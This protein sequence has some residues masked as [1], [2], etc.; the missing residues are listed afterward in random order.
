MIN[1]NS[2]LLILVVFLNSFYVCNWEIYASRSNLSRRHPSKKHISRKRDIPLFYWNNGV[3]INFGDYLSLKL[4]ERIV[5]KPIRT[6]IDSNRRK[7][8][9]VGSIFARASNGDVVWGSGVSGKRLEKTDYTFT[10][11]DIRAVRGPL[12]RQFI[13]ENFNIDCPE[14]YGDP[15]LLFP[16]FFPEFK[17]K[18][19][20][21]YEY[22]IIPHYTE[23]K[24]FPKSKYENV[25]YPT[26]PWDEVIEKILDSKFVISSAMHG[27]IVA[28]AYHIPARM[29]RITENEPMFKYQDYYAGT[30][31]PNFRFATSVEEALKMGGEPQFE[32]DL[33]KL[34]AAFPFDCWGN[35]K[36]SRK[37]RKIID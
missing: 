36:L 23:Q 1:F 30:N 31:R 35:I 5:G 3:F 16:Y 9:A 14:V 27:L 18:E 25:V 10:N 12:T 34:Y 22:I 2:K 13:M 15:V 11:L 20:P 26:D 7:L 32:C 33:E 19:S 24:L 8:L 37:N 28:E 29:L 21:S 4:V 17:K 6:K